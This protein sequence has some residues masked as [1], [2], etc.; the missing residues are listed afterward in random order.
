[1]I[2]AKGLSKSFGRKRVLQDIDL[3]EGSGEFVT[4]FGPNGA[5]KS[6]LLQIL[7]GI[8]KSNSGQIWIQ[9]IHMMKD[10]VAARRNLGFISHQP[11][12]YSE[13]TAVENLTFFGRMF[14]VPNLAQRID[15]I[16]HKVGLE[17]RAH[18]LLRTFSRG[19]IQRLTIA[20][21]L[22][23]APSIL[24]LDEP[25]TGLDQ[26]AVDMFKK[27]LADVI[28]SGGAITMATHN[29]ERGLELCHR[30]LI[31]SNGRLIFEARKQ[32][33]DRAE[34]ETIYNQYISGGKR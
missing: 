3:K 27:I 33:L 8:M 6:T 34:F 31:L 26:Q 22:L 12:L 30:A 9:G 2:E 13:L 19:M 32:D 11:L 15:E 28:G 17:L 25:F 16:I 1:M 20:R 18:D 29:L 10:P 21:A 24:L 5:G 4:I 7:A 14:D 23:H